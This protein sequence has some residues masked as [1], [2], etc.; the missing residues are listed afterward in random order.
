MSCVCLSTSMFAGS[1][2][3]NERVR[4]SRTSIGSGS[5]VRRTRAPST[6][7]RRRAARG[8]GATCRPTRTGASPSLRSACGAPDRRRAVVA[9]TQPDAPSPASTAPA[10]PRARTELSSY[11]CTCAAMR[12]PGSI[13]QIAEPRVDRPGLASSTTVHRRNPVAVAPTGT[14]RSEFAV[15]ADDVTGAHAARGLRAASL[16]RPRAGRRSTPPPSPGAV[17]VAR[18]LPVPLVDL[19]ADDHGVDVRRVGRQHHGGDRVD[20]RRG[21]GRRPVDRRPRRPACPGV[22]EPV[23]ASSP[24]DVRAV[25][26]RHRQHVPRREGVGGSGSSLAHTESFDRHRSAANAHRISVN[27]SPGTVVTTSI[28]R[29]G[30]RPYERAFADRRPAVAHLHLHLRRDRDRSLALGDQLPL[31]VAEV[32]AVDV[33][34]VGAQQPETVELLDHRPT[35]RRACPS[36][37]GR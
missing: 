2:W 31:L 29:L 27:M 15:P 4:G 17:P 37:C 18:E 21:A 6:C 8:C 12:P 32:A 34:R 36:R 9:G 16:P 19:P 1:M 20:R 25:E 30:R 22:S 24:A 3:P 13:S 7:R 23:R 26:R 10:H 28:D 14:A 11:E 33:R 5:R 35:C